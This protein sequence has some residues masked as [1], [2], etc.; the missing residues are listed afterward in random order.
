MFV[1]NRVAPQPT[2]P[3]PRPVALTQKFAVL[4]RASR[5]W[6]V[7][8]IHGDADRLATLHD[9]LWPRF[10]DGD[11]LT[12]LGNYLG[13][14]R[15]ILATVDELLRFRCAIIGRPLMFASDVVY[16]RGSQEEMW[17]KL[18]QLQFAVN[19]REVYEWMLPQGIAATIR[20]YGG[21]PDRGRAAMRD[22]PVAIGR[23]TASLRQAMAEQPGHRA[24][25]TTL[26]RAAYTDDKG[27]LFVHAGI[28]PARDL[29]EQGDAL[30]WGHPGWG[31]LDAAYCGFRRVVRGY[32]RSARNRTR[33][34][35][36]IEGVVAA[37]F[38]LTVDGGCGFGGP[39]VA[40][41]LT[42]DGEIVD[43]IEA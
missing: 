31:R 38:T 21:D 11:R 8:A 34:E 35:G 36:G 12:Y 42:P 14:E 32:D 29:S 16:L 22:G 27:L 4:R 41:C 3:A 24:W 7:P 39:L 10:G 40:L 2:R 5:I 18:L 19:P 1:A 17:E 26:R 9:A 6:V 33:V 30:W 23:W 25:I 43:Q 20:A 28:D 37:P 15:N 13:H